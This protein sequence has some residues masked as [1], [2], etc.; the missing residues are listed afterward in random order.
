MNT[1]GVIDFRGTDRIT[2]TVCDVIKDNGVNVNRT[3]TYVWAGNGS[4]LNA[5]FFC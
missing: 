1:N 4:P 2:R 3:R 5:G